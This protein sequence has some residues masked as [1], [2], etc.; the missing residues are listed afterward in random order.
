M[1]IIECY[2]MLQN[3]RVTAFTVFELLRKNQLGEQSYPPPSTQNRINAHPSEFHEKD[4][5]ATSLSLFLCFNCWLWTNFVNSFSCIINIFHKF[6]LP[7]FLRSKHHLGRISKI[8]K[9]RWCNTFLKCSIKK[10]FGTKNVL[11][12]G[13]IIKE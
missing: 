6:M 3:S 8:K 5:R 9:N 10:I 4:T 11:Q 13:M 7:L 12:I 1:S 2:W